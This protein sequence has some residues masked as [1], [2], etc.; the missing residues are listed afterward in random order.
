MEPSEDQSID[1]T[2]HRNLMKEMILSLFQQQLAMRMRISTM[3]RK[4]EK[5]REDRIK[6]GQGYDV[7]MSAIDKQIDDL[8]DKIVE[9]MKAK[10]RK[11]LEKEQVLAKQ[12]REINADEDILE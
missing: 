5:K 10:E 6:C 1:D 2:K 3:R 12:L 7:Q 9:L 4:C 8:K 11:R